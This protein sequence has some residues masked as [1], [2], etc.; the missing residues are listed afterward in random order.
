MHNQACKGRFWKPV[1]IKLPD[2]LALF[3]SVLSVLAWVQAVLMYV[4][5]RT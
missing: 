3:D 2:Y 4:Q 1:S 5:I